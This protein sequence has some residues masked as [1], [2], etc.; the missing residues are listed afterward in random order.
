[1]SEG[2]KDRRVYVCENLS[3]NKE[4]IRE[5]DVTSMQKAQVKGLN[6]IVILNENNS[7]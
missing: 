4:R 6:V 5:F 1:M 7:E 3:L 2:L